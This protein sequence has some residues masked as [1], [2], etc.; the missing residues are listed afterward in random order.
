M[1]VRPFG[2][3]CS[4]SISPVATGVSVVPIIL[5]TLYDEGWDRDNYEH[6]PE[7]NGE[8]EYGMNT[9]TPSSPGIVGH[10][11]G[12]EGGGANYKMGHLRQAEAVT[13]AYSIFDLRLRRRSRTD[14]LLEFG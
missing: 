7:A 4:H 5:L 6:P 13:D 8:E 14:A 11:L 9:S 2:G 3:A 12:L 10:P 1:S